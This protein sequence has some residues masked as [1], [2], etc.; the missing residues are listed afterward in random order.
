MGV[1]GSAGVIAVGAGSLW[2]GQSL[3]SNA[4]R[5][6]SVRRG[7]VNAVPGNAWG[8]GRRCEEG[9]VI[10]AAIGKAPVGREQFLSVDSWSC[11]ILFFR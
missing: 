2:K 9:G 1:V 10:Q 3:A 8:S 7:K 11:M 4:P 6:V 5:V